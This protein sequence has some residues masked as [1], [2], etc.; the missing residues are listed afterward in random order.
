MPQRL[1]LFALVLLPWAAP[2]PAGDEPRADGRLAPEAQAFLT[3]YC[4]K[5]HQG[6]KPKAKLDQA[7]L[8]AAP[9]L[10]GE[11]KA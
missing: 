11:A 3:T 7:R 1:P 5:C 4:L 9:S 8:P 10:A 2:V 6:E